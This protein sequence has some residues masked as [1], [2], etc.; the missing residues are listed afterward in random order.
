MSLEVMKQAH[1]A[2]FEFSDKGAAEVVVCKTGLTYGVQC[3]DFPNVFAQFV[4]ESDAKHFV[5][6]FNGTVAPRVESPVTGGGGGFESPPVPANAPAASAESVASVHIKDGCLIG[7]QRK[8]G[9]DIPDGQY[10]LYP[11]GTYPAPAVVRQLVDALEQLMS[12]V[13]IHSKATSNNFAW[14]EMDFAKEALASLKEAG[15]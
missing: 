13:K 6:I 11:I 14:A 15:L 8:S 2:L 4:F 7:S 12:I 9:V 5:N 1:A 10:G 3:V